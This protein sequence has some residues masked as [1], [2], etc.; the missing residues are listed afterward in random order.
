MPERAFWYDKNHFGIYL[1]FA[2][3]SVAKNPDESPNQSSDTDDCIHESCQQSHW[4][5]QPSN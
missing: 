1:A 5:K 3:W 4:T 2:R